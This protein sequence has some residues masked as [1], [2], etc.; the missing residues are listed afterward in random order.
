MNLQQIGIKKSFFLISLC[1]L[2]SSCY[3]EFNIEPPDCTNCTKPVVLCFITQDSPVRA[4]ATTT[5]SFSDISSNVSREFKGQIFISDSTTGTRIEL[6]MS[7]INP[8]LFSTQENEILIKSGELYTLSVYDENGNISSATTKVPE[9]FDRFLSCDI[10]GY[11]EVE[12][13]IEYITK[14]R[15]EKNSVWNNLLGYS[16]ILSAGETQ[17]KMYV[18]YNFHPTQIDSRTLE[19]FESEYWRYSYHYTLFTI[20]EPFARYIRN[21]DFFDGIN[22]GVE[23]QSFVNIFNGIIPEYTNFDNSLGVFGG[24]LTDSISVVNPYSSP[25]NK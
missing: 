21:F 18:E 19:Y 15:W 5:A 3:R 10:V 24:Y 4:I 12:D 23:T 13:E 25:Y 1:L 9:K 8:Q 11:T 2:F 16:E 20:N 14:L 22:I 6:I 7:T 17:S